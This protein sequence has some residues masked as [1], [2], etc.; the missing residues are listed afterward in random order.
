MNM[1]IPSNFTSSKHIIP[2]CL[3]GSKLHDKHTFLELDILVKLK[4]EI[5]LLCPFQ[6]PQKQ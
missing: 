4:Q 5:F 6:L 3:G 1:C 2:K